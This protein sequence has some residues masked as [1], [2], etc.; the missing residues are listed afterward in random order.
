MLKGLV[1]PT[2]YP[3]LERENSLVYVFPK[4]IRAIRNVNN[5]IQVLN[6]D[7][8]VHFLTI[9]TITPWTTFSQSAG[10]VEFINCTSAEG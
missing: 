2:I 8:R 5:P 10:A 9:V 7:H 4:G 3:L 6:W 1:C